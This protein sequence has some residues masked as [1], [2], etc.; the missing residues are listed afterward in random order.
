MTLDSNIVPRAL[1]LLGPLVLLMA[2]HG[3]ASAQKLVAP[4][5]RQAFVQPTPYD[6]LRAFVRLL[7]V[8]RGIRTMVMATTREGREIPAVLISRSASFGQDTSKLRVML[9]A[10]QHGDEPSGK[11]A[12]TLLLADCADGVFD[13]L[14]ERLDLIVVPQMNPDGAERR[15]R[16]NADQIDLNR[17]HLLLHTPEVLGLHELFAA[18]MPEVTVD[19]HEYGSF[20]SDWR[21]AGFVKTTD[22]QFGLLTNLNSP[23]VV[24]RFQRGVVFPFIAASMAKAGYSFSEY[25]VGS[26]QDRLRHSTTEINDGRQSFGILGTL[27]FIQEGRKWRSLE[28]H[29][30]RRARSQYASLR[31]LLECAAARSIEIKHLVADARRGLAK[32]AGSTMV[33]RM[34]HRPGDRSMSIPVRDLKTDRDTTWTVAPYHGTVIAL[35]S[36][37]I[38]SAYIIP[39]ELPA[40]VELLKRH[41]VRFN[42]LDRPER[43]RV[44]EYAVD[45]I[46]VVVIEEDSLPAPHLRLGSAERELRPGDIVV[47]TDQLHSMFLATALEPASL[48]GLLKYPAFAPDLAADGKYRILRH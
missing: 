15:Q 22:V 1:T 47:P 24:R 32:P 4:I 26:P 2:L 11:E 33:T 13:G 38:P 39:R 19:I 18:W 14:L 41:R 21:D 23:A 28:D 29:L 6:S 46:G 37:V 44:G 45:S 48:W 27:S 40:V 43:V 12:L 8:S 25:L 30:E 10:Q 5:E 31:A 36:V 16:R 7:P 17:S 34:D 35:D 9:F 20:S 3:E 42:V